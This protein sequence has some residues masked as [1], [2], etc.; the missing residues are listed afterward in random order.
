MNKSPREIDELKSQSLNV[1]YTV[2]RAL[3]LALRGSRLSREQVCDRM[4]ELA[5]Q[6]GMRKQISKATLDNWT[7]DSDP[8]RLPSLAWL[9][10]FCEV[11]EAT[12]PLEALAR[13]LGFRVI[14]REQG[15][16]LKWGQADLERRRAVRRAEAA[17]A[18][19][20]GV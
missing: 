7:K 1:V 18:E 20:E 3:R 2:K 11:L 17:L 14:D 15:R 9:V 5:A 10:I 4:N 16:I 13:P 8:D 6:E 19:I 12:G